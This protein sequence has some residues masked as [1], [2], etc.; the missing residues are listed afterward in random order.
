ML[1]YLVTFLFILQIQTPASELNTIIQKKWQDNKIKPSVSATKEEWTR[2][3]YL[4]LFGRLPTM[5]EIN[6]KSDL[7]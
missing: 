5:D 2:R 4:D 3:V 7:P 6:N 1:K